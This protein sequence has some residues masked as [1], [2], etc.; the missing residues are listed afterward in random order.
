MT[1]WW[2]TWPCIERP[3]IQSI[4]GCGTPNT[5]PWLRNGWCGVGL[6]DGAEYT[7]RRRVVSR[8]EQLTGTEIA[9][10]IEQ[11][12]LKMIQRLKQLNKAAIECQQ[13]WLQKAI[14]EV[15][16][17]SKEDA[18]NPRWA[19]L[20]ADEGSEELYEFAVRELVIELGFTNFSRPLERRVARPCA[21]TMPKALLPPP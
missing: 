6:A 3:R 15:A 1:H 9:E 19:F 13:E 20:G 12:V 10:A 8:L 18:C 17:Q 16:K 21:E 14:S 4:R 5:N 11:H 2:P 7:N